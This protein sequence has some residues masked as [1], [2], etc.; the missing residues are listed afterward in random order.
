M[1]INGF[2]GGRGASPSVAARAS[3]PTKGGAAPVGEKEI[4]AAKKKVE[5]EIGVFLGVSRHFTYTHIS[6]L[7]PHTHALT[8]YLPLHH[9]LS[10]TI[11]HLT[12]T[13]TDAVRKKKHTPLQ[14]SIHE[15]GDGIRKLRIAAFRGDPQRAATETKTALG[16]QGR[17]AEL[18]KIFA[19]QNPDPVVKRKAEDAVRELENLIPQ[20]VTSISSLVFL[21]SFSSFLYISVFFSI[22]LS[23]SLLYS[24]S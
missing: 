13:L 12:H 20:Q 3:T 5:A 19:A 10:T 16:K 9:T 23:I 22:L 7:T 11:T 6:H 21:L 4:E 17:V 14:A 18:A 24:V 2:L 8:L 1:F 15:A